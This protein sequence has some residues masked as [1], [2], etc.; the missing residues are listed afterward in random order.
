MPGVR[1]MT[2]VVAIVLLSCLACPG[3]VA[4]FGDVSS[5]GAG[6]GDCGPLVLA[7]SAGL[8]S[9]A[10][11]ANGATGLPTPAMN[12]TVPTPPANA[13]NTSAPATQPAGAGLPAPA[14]GISVLGAVGAAGI[15]AR[16]RDRDG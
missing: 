14:A 5:P 8:V 7:A 4:A 1:I 13:S 16:G 12:G 15:L 9:E 6:P 11:P 3:T 2:I 10:G